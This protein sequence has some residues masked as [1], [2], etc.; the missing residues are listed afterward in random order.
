VIAPVAVAV[1]T[2]DSAAD[3]PGCLAAIGRLD[4]PPAELRV[5]DCAS[6]DASVAIARSHL[7][8]G[9]GDARVLPLGENRGFSGGSNAAIATSASPWILTLNPDAEPAPDYLARLLARAEASPQPPAGAVTGRLVRRA[10]AGEPARLDACGMRLGRAWRHFDRGSGEPDRGQYG[11]AERVFGATG[12][13]TLWRRAA[14]ADVAL[15]G[16]F[17]DERFHSYREDAELCFRL[18]ERGWAVLYEP[19]ALAVH[20][21]R[22]LPERRRT[23]PAAINFH[24]LKNRYLLRAGHQRAGNL[25]RTLPW[26]LPR[27][28]G[29]L[30]WVLAVERSSL[31]AYGWLWRHR[32]EIRARRRALLARATAP[33]AAVERWFGTDGEPL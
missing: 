24:S 33:A 3:L 19:A 5:V 2:H 26:T 12:A 29:A 28:L 18:H 23:L 27:D 9:P 22:V 11:A 21:R 30:L 16:E 31:R 20:G 4:P 32:R 1:V 25:L 8:A 17:F 10:A 7:P 15:D 6:R 14:L 13:A